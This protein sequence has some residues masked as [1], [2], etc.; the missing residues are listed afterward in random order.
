MLM[1]FLL[2]LFIPLYK[3]GN[4]CVFFKFLHRN[5]TLQTKQAGNLTLNNIE[6]VSIM[7]INSSIKDQ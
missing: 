5:I 4:S 3:L 6:L 2:K 1:F 7:N